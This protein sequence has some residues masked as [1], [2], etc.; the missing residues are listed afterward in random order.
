VKFLIR[1]YGCQMNVR[2]SE[3]IAALLVQR[4][5]REVTAEREADIIIVN[6]CSVREKAEDKALGKLRLLVAG[7]ARRGRRQIV[8]AVGCMVQRLGDSIFDRVRGLSF[9]AAPRSLYMV[10][11]MVEAAQHGRERLLALDEP[12]MKNDALT[13]H[14]KGAVS[15]YINILLGCDRHC[16][17]CIVPAVRGSE[18]SRPASSIMAEV[19]G[20]AGQGVRE[21]VLLGQSVMSYG[22]KN[23]TW[24]PSVRSPSGYRDPFSRLLEAVSGVPGIS[25]IR[26]TSGHP[27]GCV[28]ELARAMSELPPVCEHLHLPLQSGCDRILTGM[29]RGYVSDDYRQAVT[30]L[31][32]SVP[33]LALTTDIMVGYPGET[34]AEFEET[35]KFMDEIGFDNSFIFKYSPRPGTPAAELKD[36]VPEAEKMRRNKVLLLDQDRQSILIHQ[37]LIG[38]EIEVMLEGVSQR[39]ESRWAGRTRTGKIVIFDPVPGCNPGELINV[40]IRR[41]AAQT[42]YGEAVRG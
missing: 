14:V 17:Y 33:G 12:G 22:R 6:T 29:K 30:L 39:N 2:D 31:R 5:H 8:G 24:D 23:E 37:R 27:S 1:T 4:D 10:A 32:R 15:A 38:Q 21:I 28:P 35:R 26:F 13:N 7:G 42:L 25:R 36:D 18:W 19:K 40:K 34:E 9:A 20:L 16:S 3:S 11:D 41:V